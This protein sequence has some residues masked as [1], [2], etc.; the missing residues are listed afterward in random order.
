MDFRTVVPP[1]EGKRGLVRH[2]EPLLLI[3]SCFSDNIGSCLVSDLFEADVNPFGPLYNPLSI[4]KAFELI[5]GRG[6]V[7]AS[8]L[9]K[10]DGAWVST[11]FHSRV[12]D[13]DRDTALEKMN[14]AVSESAGHLREASVVIITLG[15]TRVFT[16]RDGGDVV[17]NCHK[18]PGSMFDVRY[19][20]LEE[21]TES[22]RSILSSIR[23]VNA[24]AEVIFTVSPLRY[25]EQGAHGNQLSKS[26]LLLGIDSLMRLSSDPKVSYFPAYE[27]MMDD[28]RDYRFYAEDMKH[29]TPQAVRYI[30]ELFKTSYFDAETLKL[31]SEA[32]SLTRR[33]AHRTLSSSPEAAAEETAGKTA[34]ADAF[35][36]RFPKLK[37]ACARYLSIILN[38]GIQHF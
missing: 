38:D 29:P 8:T 3:G 2:G 6:E 23:A 22:L 26:T 1:V 37:R 5:G 34:M 10:R 7:P 36:E 14:R 17:A 21:V 12:S 35:A 30:Y 19:L 9:V 4:A 20:S 33:L 31:A 11:L 28:L 24:E 15:T 13:V 32:A 18:L 25:S 16:L 27:V